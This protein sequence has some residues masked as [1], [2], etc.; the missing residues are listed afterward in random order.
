MINILF[1]IGE[2]KCEVTEMQKGQVPWTSD[3]IRRW[4]QIFS[5]PQLSALSQSGYV[6]L[7]WFPTHT[8][9]VTTPKDVL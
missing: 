4:T 5:L 7:A 2:E 9:L 8:Y 6:I 1:S 3:T